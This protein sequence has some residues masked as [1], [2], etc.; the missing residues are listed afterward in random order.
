ME[1]ST[2]SFKEV[3]LLNNRSSVQ[4]LRKDCKRIVQLFIVSLFVSALTYRLGVCFGES[5]VCLGIS[6]AATIISRLFLKR[7]K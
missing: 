6:F 2:K 4:E 1:Q 3:R 7:L 5:L